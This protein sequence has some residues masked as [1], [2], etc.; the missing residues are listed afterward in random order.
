MAA[1][2]SAY[3]LQGHAY[4][5]RCIPRRSEPLVHALLREQRMNRENATAAGCWLLAAG[6]LSAQGGSRCGPGSHGRIACQCG[7]RLKT[8]GILAP[9]PCLIPPTP[10]SYKGPARLRVADLSV[11]GRR[12]AVYRR[13]AAPL[14]YLIK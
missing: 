2:A 3:Q 11:S 6:W 4:I 12:F 7:V 14:R 1:G 8:V 9:E 5:S 13:K 10:S